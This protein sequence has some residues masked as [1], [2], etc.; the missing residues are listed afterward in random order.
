LEVL[1][2]IGGGLRGVEKEMRRLRKEG[3]VEE[4]KDDRLR[5]EDEEKRR[6]EEEK[7]EV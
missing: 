3:V 7:A 4:S 5:R 1:G 6:E 2:E